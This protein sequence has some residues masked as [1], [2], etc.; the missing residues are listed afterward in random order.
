MIVNDITPY[1][2]GTLFYGPVKSWSDAIRHFAGGFLK[3][4]PG[5][6]GEG[7]DPADNGLPIADQFPGRNDLGLPMTNPPPPFNVP[8]AFNAI[9]SIYALGNFRGNENPVLLMNGIIWMR[10]HNW[11]AWSTCCVIGWRVCVCFDLMCRVG[12][13]LA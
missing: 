2:D 13:G 7:P 1:I 10:R 3:I 9:N 11:W 12:Q 6:N 8:Q 4:T 5:P